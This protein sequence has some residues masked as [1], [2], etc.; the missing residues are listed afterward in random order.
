MQFLSF[1]SL[2]ALATATSAQKCQL[3]FDGRVPVGSTPAS[4][5]VNTSPFGTKN[6]F[7]QN[8]TWSK[9]IVLPNITRSLF[10]GTA[11]I[12]LEVT[13]SDASIFAPSAT[14]IQTG[15]R[16]AEL[17]PASNN[18]T[19]PSTLGVKTLHFSVRKDNARPLNISHEYQLVFLEDAKFTTNQFVLKTGTIAGQPAGQ[20]PDLLVLQGNVN[21]PVIENL[22]NVSFTA[23]VWHNFALTLNFTANTVQTF[24]SQNAAALASVTGVV[25]NDLSGQGQFHFGALKKGTGVNLTDVTKQGFQESG[26]NEGVI[27]G[28]IFEEISTC[29]CVSLC[30]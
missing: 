28:G 12:P 15:F 2:L 27:Y 1:L 4:F 6:V 20:N 14:N 7:G 8:L 16:R 9:I 17:N 26:I 22:F 5:D 23:N 18:G 19:D 11:N 10:D 13:L 29:G 3:Q 21:A 25:S 24:Y 30:P